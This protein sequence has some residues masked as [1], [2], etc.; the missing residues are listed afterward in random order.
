MDPRV[1]SYIR[2]YGYWG[3][4]LWAV[5]GGEEGLVVAV[6]LAKKGLLNLPGV[7]A[8]AALGG[9]VGDQIY[10]YLGRRYGWRRLQRSARGRRA[11]E[12]AQVLLARYGLGV[13]VVSR[14]LAGLRITIPLVCGMLGMSPLIYSVLN[15][16][17]A[18]L[19]ASFYGIM[20]NFVWSVIASSEWRVWVAV[21]VLAALTLILLMR[22]LWRRPAGAPSAMK[23]H[24]GI[25]SG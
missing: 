5:L 20:L 7:I 23:D 10:F 18:L 4:F 22:L 12:R 9:A 16:L 6:W 13:V 11:I 19:W 1:E 21:V 14:F 15:F 2:A 8:A 25:D 24:V 3:I 17:S